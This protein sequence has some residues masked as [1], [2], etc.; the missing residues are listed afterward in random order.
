M[1]VKALSFIRK[2][3]FLGQRIG[4]EYKGLSIYRSY[5]GGVYSFLIISITIFI[6]IIFGKDSLLRESPFVSLSESF[7]LSSDI[8]L[9]DFPIIVGFGY[10]NGTSMRNFSQYYNLDLIKFQLSD[11][12]IPSQV[13][14]KDGLIDCDEIKD[15]FQR[16]KEL[17]IKT[18][19]EF[20]SFHRLYCLKF[21]LMEI[22]TLLTLGSE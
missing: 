5:A 6:G 2:I 15:T 16:N 10:S 8:Y 7:S 4:F 12:G 17:F 11:K 9:R 1:H 18:Y 19:T 14:I 21:D 3:D 20:K 22:L 13:Y